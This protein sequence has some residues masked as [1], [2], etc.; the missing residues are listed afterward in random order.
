MKNM[1]IIVLF[2]ST[3]ISFIQCVRLKNERDAALIRYHDVIALYNQQVLP[4]NNQI[5]ELEKK[6]KSDGI[7]R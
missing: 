7:G 1:I 6:W 4:M 3:M 5:G 2:I